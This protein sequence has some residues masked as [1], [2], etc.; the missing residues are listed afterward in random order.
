[1]ARCHVVK[2]AMSIRFTFILVSS[3]IE[4][5]VMIML[6]YQLILAH[7]VEISIAAVDL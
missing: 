4:E 2:L 1:M 7:R 5:S 6:G 3:L